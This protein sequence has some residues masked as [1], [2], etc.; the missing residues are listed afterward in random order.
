MQQSR[1][2]RQLLFPQIGALEHTYERSVDISYCHQP[3]DAPAVAASSDGVMFI[4]GGVGQDNP[5]EEAVD[6]IETIYSD[7]AMFGAG[8]HLEFRLPRPCCFAAAVCDGRDNLWVAGGSTSIYRGSRVYSHVMMLPRALWCVSR[9][10]GVPAQRLVVGDGDTLLGPCAAPLHEARCGHA[11]LYSR[12]EDA[13]YAVGGYGGGVRYHD[14]VE[15]FALGSGGGHGFASNSPAWQLLG[16]GAIMS[17]A[18]TG[19]GASFGPDGAIYAVGGSPD[20]E[21][22]LSTFERFDPRA[23]AWQMLPPMPTARGYLT[24]SFGL[25][26]C[27][28]AAGGC[29]AGAGAMEA[30]DV[31]ER[32]DVRASCWEAQ[33]DWGS[34]PQHVHGRDC[35]S[36]ASDLSTMSKN[37]RRFI[38]PACTCALNFLSTARQNC[39]STFA[40]F[41]HM[42]PKPIMMGITDAPRR[43]HYSMIEKR[44]E[45]NNMDIMDMDVMQDHGFE[46][47]PGFEPL[48]ISD[49]DPDHDY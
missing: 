42:T 21:H 25:D 32:F 39:G 28:Y 3:R 19:L 24:A 31:I 7:G 18:R 45:P 40:L 35:S 10:D 15:R 36:R 43:T 29:L 16:G 5:E 2:R 8:E 22:M 13:L 1:P 27:F 4:C 41:P 30:C 49:D 48:L 6:T 26:G 44:C 20:G 23:G 17:S 9:D 47:E 33:V 34:E 46:P 14:T 11:L 37:N 38:H 12:R